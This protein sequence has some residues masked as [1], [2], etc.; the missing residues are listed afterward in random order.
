LAYSIGV[1]VFE[2]LGI[3]AGTVFDFPIAYQTFT[4]AY[5]FIAFTK[6]NVIFYVLYVINRYLLKRRAVPVLATVG[7]NIL[8]YI[9]MTLALITVLA[10]KLLPIPELNVGGVIIA[11]LAALALFLVVSVPLKKKNILFKL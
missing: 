2:I 10:L 9:F 3:V 11:D 8:L 6:V 7:R 4:P 5:L 1:G